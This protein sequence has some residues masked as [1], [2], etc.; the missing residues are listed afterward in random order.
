M[1]KNSRALIISWQV[2]IFFTKLSIFQDEIKRIYY[3]C[4]DKA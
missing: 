3:N 4:Q 2:G 1:E